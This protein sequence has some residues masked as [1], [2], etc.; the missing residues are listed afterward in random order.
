MRPMGPRRPAFS[1]RPP[2]TY[3]VMSTV[4]REGQIS[5]AASIAPDAIWDHCAF[6]SMSTTLT[7]RPSC[8]SSRFFA[9][10][11]VGAGPAHA[12][13]ARTIVRVWAEVPPASLPGVEPP[14]FAPEPQPL[15]VMQSTPPRSERRGSRSITN[16]SSGARARLTEEALVLVAAFAS[17][18]L[19]AGLVLDPSTHEGETGLRWPVV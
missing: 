11:Q 4:C 14:A 13:R 1:T 7:V 9:R 18:D 6:S 15:N 5:S 8:R 17:A 3:F 19:D 12:L 10:A 16:S 2:V